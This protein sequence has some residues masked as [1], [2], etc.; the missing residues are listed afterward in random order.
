MNET[1]GNDLHKLI[2]IM[3]QSREGLEEWTRWKHFRTRIRS[4]SL[5]KS[6][7][8]MLQIQTHKRRMHSCDDESFFL[9]C[10]VYHPQ[11]NSE[12]SFSLFSCFEFILYWLIDAT[13]V[14]DDDV[15]STSFLWWCLGINDVLM[16]EIKQE[17]GCSCCCRY[18]FVPE[19]ELLPK[20]EVIRVES[21]YEDKSFLSIHFVVS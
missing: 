5:E 19:Q 15:L 2:A 9:E 18:S 17:A 1:K 20:R 16:K 11:Y 14:A 13:A 21:F 8:L 10:I 6:T 7:D 3:K 12:S 4:I